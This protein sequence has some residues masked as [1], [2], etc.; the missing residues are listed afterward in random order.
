MPA[1]YHGIIKRFFILSLFLSPALLHAQN[2]DDT[3]KS[4]ISE[5][6]QDSTAQVEPPPEEKQVYEGYQETPTVKG[7]VYFLN[8]SLQSHGGGP[9]SLQV[10]KLP[11]T[12]TKR[13]KQEEDFWYV[14]YEFDKKKKDEKAEAEKKAGNEEKG[15]T[16]D[17][18]KV[19]RP[20]TDEPFFQ[21]FLWLII[22]G[23][24]AA[25]VVLYL[26]NSNANLF[27]RKSKMLGSEAEEFVET[28][29]IFEINYQRE[30]DKAV[31]NG[32]YRFA[33]RL[34]FLRVLKNLSEKRVIDYTHDRTNFDYLS[35]VH[36]TKYYNDFFRLTLNY[37]YSWY[38]QFD[39][40]AQKFDVIKNEFEKFD[41]S[42]K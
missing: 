15:K 6:P 27:R 21:T 14:N 8:K 39:I 7:S 36:S 19:S 29:N 10:R 22:I 24:F 20:I 42:L 35:Q 5:M 33:I 18:I 40:D 41:R 34:L 12:L 13:L 31:S 28:D 17:K 37:E 2:Q 4:I 38:G 30:I 25:C 1:K 3:V 26:S 32:N 16:E 23:G 9:D 11:D